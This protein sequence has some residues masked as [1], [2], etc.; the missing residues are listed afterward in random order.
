M[1]P[2]ADA[3][4][5]YFVSQAVAATR[6]KAVLSGV[7][8]DE[9]FGGYPSF[10]RIPSALRTAKWLAPVLP[11]TVLA[12]SALSGLARA[13]VAAFRGAP[14]MR[15]PRIAR[16]AATSCPRSGRACSVR[17]STERSDAMR[18]RR[19]R[20]SRRVDVAR[21]RARDAAG[22][23]VARWRRRLFARAAYC[24]TSMPCRWRTA[25][26]SACRLSIIGSPAPSGLRSD[27]TRTCSRA[28][29]SCTKAC[30]ALPAGCRRPSEARLHAALRR[31]DARRPSR[32]LAARN[33]IGRGARLGERAGGGRRLERLGARPCA[34]VACVGTL[35]C[36]DSS[37]RRPRERGPVARC[38]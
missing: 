24:V 22:G 35:G 13:E 4:N 9:M 6:V 34:L 10:Q 15:H 25:S 14:R 20:G 31:L 12:A 38:R 23:G 27:I 30:R 3:I 29:V 11:V 7:G 18:A 16:C 36:S 19:S 8:G 5:S 32:D 26:R 28:S 37:C 33:R 1:Q 17:P 21:R 2:S